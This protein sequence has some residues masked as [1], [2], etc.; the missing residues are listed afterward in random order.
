MRNCKTSSIQDSLYG[1][2]VYGLCDCI[3]I[4]YLLRSISLALFFTRDLGSESK[5]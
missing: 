5:Q 3:V 4:F 2:R 1:S